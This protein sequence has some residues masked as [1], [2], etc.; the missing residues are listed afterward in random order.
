[1]CEQRTVD[2]QSDGGR[3]VSSVVVNATREVGAVV[4]TA[5]SNVQQRRR[6]GELDRCRD[7]CNTGA[8]RRAVPIPRDIRCRVAAR[9]LARQPDVFRLAWVT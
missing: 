2:G 3:G 4:F 8:Q 1:M 5:Q 7:V 6:L 9:R